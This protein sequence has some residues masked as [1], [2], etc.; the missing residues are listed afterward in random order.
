M[1]SATFAQSPMHKISA[2]ND[3]ARVPDHGLATANLVFN[4]LFSVSEPLFCPTGREAG[5]GDAVVMRLS[6]AST[7]F[8]MPRGRHVGRCLC[9]VAAVASGYT[10]VVVHHLDAHDLKAP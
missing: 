10:G 7:R 2:Q 9:P 3:G 8:S 5:L 4:L 6:I 1:E